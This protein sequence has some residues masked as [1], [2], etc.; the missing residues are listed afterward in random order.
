[1]RR[2]LLVS[3]VLA[4]LGACTPAR[5]AL[6]VV[7]PNP[8]GSAGAVTL[9]DGGK[10]V[11]LDQPYAAGEVR[12]GVAA[13][14]A[15]TPE[16]VE[17]LFG[18][19]LAARPILPSHFLLY[20]ITDTDKLTPD[21]ERQYRDV[22]G[23]IKRRPAY[24]VEVV[25]HT[26]TMG[27]RPYNQQLSLKRAGA[28]RD[29]LVQDGLSAKAISIAGRGQLDLAVPTKDQVSEARNRRVEITVR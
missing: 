13:P 6:V 27:D 4:A 1:M 3:L 22:F 28:I 25:G 17:K 24:E 15:I 20:F 21:S 8:D 19:A 23:D 29:Q 11:L 9:V 5:Q 16:E 12:A 2:I 18:Q 7:L 26:D 10:S 14:V